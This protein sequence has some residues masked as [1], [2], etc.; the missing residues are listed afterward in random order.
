MEKLLT[1]PVL[2]TPQI[3]STNA[4]STTSLRTLDRRISQSQAPKEGIK[5]LSK[6]REDYAVSKYLKHYLPTPLSSEND[7]DLQFKISL[8]K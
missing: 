2:K 6:V 4:A 5:P 7:D 1:R 3:S 8:A